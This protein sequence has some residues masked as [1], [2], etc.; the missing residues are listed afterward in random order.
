MTPLGRKIVLKLPRFF[1]GQY[2]SDFK[3]NVILDQM[4]SLI[5]LLTGSKL[6]FPEKQP[7][8]RTIKKA[9]FYLL[10]IKTDKI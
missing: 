5:V 4:E 1:T 10:L 2:G 6:A 3:T 7:K 9:K 8:I